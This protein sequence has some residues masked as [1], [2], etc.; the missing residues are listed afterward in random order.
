M[1]WHGEQTSLGVVTGARMFV[2]QCSNNKI[3]SYHPETFESSRCV[4]KRP[5]LALALLNVRKATMF[6]PLRSQV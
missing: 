1:V 6:D 4:R 3:P 5:S 2:D